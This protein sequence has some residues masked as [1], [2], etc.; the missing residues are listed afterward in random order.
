MTPAVGG[1]VIMLV[2]VSLIPIA[3]DLWVGYPGTPHYSSWENLSVGA[4]TLVIILILGVFGSP[5]VRLWSPIAGTFFGYLAG[6]DQPLDRS[7]L[8]GR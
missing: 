4:L 1:V 3:M 2:S 6:S 7:E 8:E 5:Q